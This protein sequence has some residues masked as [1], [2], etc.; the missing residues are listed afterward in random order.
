MLPDFTERYDIGERNNRKGTETV[1]FILVAETMYKHQSFDLSAAVG[2]LMC[3]IR[4]YPVNAIQYVGGGVV[5]A[6]ADIHTLDGFVKTHE[7]CENRNIVLE[8][9]KVEYVIE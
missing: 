8:H 3:E 5:G 1:E 2:Q 4:G 6:C 7:K 9:A